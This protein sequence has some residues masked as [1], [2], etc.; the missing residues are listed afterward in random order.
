MDKKHH[1]FEQ[2]ESDRE[3]LKEDVESF[4]EGC[5]EWLIEWDDGTSRTTTIGGIAYYAHHFDDGAEVTC[6]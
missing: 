4:K 2:V 3:L 5:S 1:A 6:V